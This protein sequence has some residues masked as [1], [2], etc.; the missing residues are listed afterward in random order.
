MQ[1]PLSPVPATRCRCATSGIGVTGA[2]FLN[3]G[4]S[5]NDTTSA[6]GGSGKAN[7]DRAA[8]GASNV[9]AGQPTVPAAGP[10][11]DAQAIACPATA[12]TLKTPGGGGTGQFG[13]NGP[14]FPEPVQSIKICAYREQGGAPIPRADG[15]PE[16]TV[17][18]GPQATALAA[19]LDAAPT[20][21]TSQICPQYR[22]AD[23]KTLA[24]IGLSTSGKAMTPVTATVSQNPCNLPVTNGAAIR[25]NWSPP[26]SLSTFLAQL[27]DTRATGGPIHVPPSGTVTG[28][29]IHS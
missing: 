10:L 3:G 5:S 8:R 23:G 28:S 9:R 18:T 21:R 7:S 16:N 19:S 24:I 15:T 6:A 27:P 14:L 29:P 26:A 4:A 12:P 17:L 2:I 20:E 25:Y 13:A 11:Q 22:S 1:T